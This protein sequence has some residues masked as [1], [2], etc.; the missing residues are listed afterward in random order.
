MPSKTP[1]PKN[2][3]PKKQS[4]DPVLMWQNPQSKKQRS[5]KQ[6]KEVLKEKK[7]E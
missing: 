3:R 6:E 1:A 2:S 4:Q 5:A 7:T